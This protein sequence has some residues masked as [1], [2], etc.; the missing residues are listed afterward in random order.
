MRFAGDELTCV[1]GDRLVFEGVSF[2]LE[3]G[4]ALVL[5]GP[6]GSGKS[7]LL[8]L[9][10][11]LLKPAAGRLT[12]DGGDI[13]GDPD[14]HRARLAYVGHLDA[15]KPALTVRDNLGFWARLNGG[16]PDVAAAAVDAG[17]R[18]L[19]LDHLHDLPA[20]F[21]SA[22]QRRRVNLARL[23]LKPV[24]LWLLDEPTAAL[25]REA[26]GIVA[27]IIAEHRRGGGMVM[28]ASHVDLGIDRAAVL[29]LGAARAAA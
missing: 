26:A 9:A 18:R 1:R 7:S 29:R 4:G 16:A 13:A 5:E 3:S 20:R 24:P 21:L 12:W 6:N 2:A 28:A 23:L 10:A 15:L 8:R 19:R 22:G 27:E 17:L 14:G 25:D 11:T